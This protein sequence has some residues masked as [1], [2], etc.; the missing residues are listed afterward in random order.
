[1]SD[2]Y[3]GWDPSFFRSP[4]ALPAPQF[5]GLSRSDAEALARSAG[6]SDIRVADLD[7]YPS[8]TLRMDRRSQRLTLLVHE[9]HVV[10][11]AFF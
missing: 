10:R 2:P 7:L 4:S 6:I 5:L 9:G 3:R 1:V 11:A 8:A